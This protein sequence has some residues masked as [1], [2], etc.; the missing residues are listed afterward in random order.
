MQHKL[1]A[2]CPLPTNKGIL[3]GE[4]WRGASGRLR[5]GASLSLLRRRRRGGFL[6]HRRQSQI[7]R[8]KNVEIPDQTEAS[9]A[10]GEPAFLLR[11]FLVAYSVVPPHIIRSPSCAVAWQHPVRT[12]PSVPQ[13][14]GN[15]LVQIP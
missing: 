13:R 8:P 5:S 6:T 2:E 15:H 9:G 10:G 7:D 12:A 1:V 14:S 11:M 4:L 3:R